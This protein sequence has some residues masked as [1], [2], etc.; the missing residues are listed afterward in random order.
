MINYKIIADS[1]EFY[2]LF[3][4][5]QTEV[6][7]TVPKLIS[8]ITK[9]DGKRDF[10][11]DG[12]ILVASAEQSFLYEYYKK[13]LKHGSYQATTACFRDDDV[14]NLHTKYFIKN[15]LIKTDVV[16]EKELD[17]VISTC[18]SFFELKIRDKVEIEKTNE[19]YDLTYKGTELGS[20]GIRTCPFLQWIYGTGC[21]EPRLSSILK[22]YGISH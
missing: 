1:I 3:G 10:Y 4:F 7:W 5:I 14:D 13:S 9:P 12:E 8:D 19:G 16:N 21:A 2:K 17:K 11:F 20:Y 22:Q 15:E 18:K 6:Q